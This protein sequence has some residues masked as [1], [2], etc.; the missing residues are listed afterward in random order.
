M[1]RSDLFES[2]LS[3]NP[4]IG[5]VDTES[6]PIKP[7]RRQ[8][9]APFITVV[10]AFNIYFAELG[11]HTHGMGQVRH[12]GSQREPRGIFTGFWHWEL[13]PREPCDGD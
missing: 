6:G 10:M 12:Q 8:V 2:C 3:D 5:D 11:R 1:R 13:A 7:Y 4:L 9:P